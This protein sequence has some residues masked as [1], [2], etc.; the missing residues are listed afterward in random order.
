MIGQRRFSELIVLW[1]HSAKPAFFSRVLLKRLRLER[2]GIQVS[3][4]Q[5]NGAKHLS[6]RRDVIRYVSVK[7]I[8]FCAQLRNV[9]PLLISLECEKTDTEIRG[10]MRNRSV[11][12]RPIGKYIHTTGGLRI[13]NR[14]KSA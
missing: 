9:A 14:K 4:L 8:F 7:Q 1:L 5:F 13:Q 3:R 12:S 11:T 2:D 10:Q 6:I